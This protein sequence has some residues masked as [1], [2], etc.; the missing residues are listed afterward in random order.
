MRKEPF[1]VDWDVQKSFYDNLRDYFGYYSGTPL[2]ELACYA[3]NFVNVAD[4]LWERPKRQR[5]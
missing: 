5:V 1:S 2:A 3:D 4:K